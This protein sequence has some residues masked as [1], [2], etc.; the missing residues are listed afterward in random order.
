MKCIGGLGRAMV[1]GRVAGTD[2]HQGGGP[3]S[4]RARIELFVW[5]VVGTDPRLHTCQQVLCH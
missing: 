5:F 3:R 1:A 4:P 2:C